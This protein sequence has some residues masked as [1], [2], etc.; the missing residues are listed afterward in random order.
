MSDAGAGRMTAAMLRKLRE[1]PIVPGVYVK[2]TLGH[3]F[4]SAEALER[5]GYV[6]IRARD[7]GKL[8]SDYEW[9]V[10]PAGR[11]AL[12]EARK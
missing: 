11:R 12:T 9:C 3:D 5:R 6:H 2:L 1:T 7:P 4:R 10:T 8:M